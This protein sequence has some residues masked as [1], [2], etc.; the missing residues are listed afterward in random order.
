MSS[1]A[2]ESGV[3]LQGRRRWFA[4]MFLALGVAMI[5]LDAT[6]VNVAIPTMVKDLNLTTADAE[7][8]TAAY[9]L[10]FASLLILAGRLADRFG[11]RLMFVAGVIVFVAASV[12]VAA[13]DSSSTLIAARALQGVGGAMILPSSLSVLN[14]VFVG[15]ARAVAF[16]VWGGTIGGMAALGPLVGG[17]LTTYASWHWAFLINVPIGI[18]VLVGVLIT[19][20][21]TKALGGPRGIDPL[22]TVLIIVAL[23]GIVFALIEGQRYGWFTPQAEFS[24]AGW[25]WP[26]TTVSIVF[27]SAVVGLGALALFAFVEIRRAARGKTVVVDLRLFRIRTF[28][29]G[30]VVALVVSLGEFGLLFGIPLFLQAVR[31]YDALQTG[32]I[33]LALA[34]GSFVASGLGAPLSQR[35]GPV[36]V[37]QTGMAL[38]ALGIL[39]L[40]FTL[41]TEVTGWQ[42]AP[43]L[44]MYGMG[45]GFATAQLTGVILSEVPVAESGQAS[46]VQSTSRQVGAAIGTAIIGTTLVLGLGTVQGH[47]EDLGVPT[48]QAAQVSDIVA[49][50]A[51]Q[52]IP[53]LASQPNGAVLVEGASQGFAE[54]IT[55]VAWVAGAF[56]LLGLLTSLVL[57]KNAARVESEGYSPP[58]G[59]PAA[60]E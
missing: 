59:A 56:V 21:E 60:A 5:I 40:G 16:A 4:L 28:G 27:V 6:V 45:V 22:G 42:M 10:T 50:S 48:A 57:P 44:F 11:R 39:A 1:E 24:A 14:A 37:L 26:S 33:L 35:F 2:A 23:L 31:G 15:R 17:W 52:A 32:V 29:A 41:S 58:R 20:P 47:L 55:W 3:A 53:A 7:W 18:L 25:T 13:S 34:G 54:A 51:G 43:W 30:N 36:R 38:E 19:V 9:A 49:T 46:A 12:L 8:V